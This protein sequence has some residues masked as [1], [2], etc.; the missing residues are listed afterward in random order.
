MPNHQA[1][2]YELYDKQAT[3]PK[4]LCDKVVEPVRPF[5]DRVERFCRL[6]AE[7]NRQA[8]GTCR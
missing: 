7:I 2:T 8:G 4:V 1:N 3:N 6:L 5:P